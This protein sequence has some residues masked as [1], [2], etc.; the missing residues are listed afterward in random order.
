[1]GSSCVSRRPCGVGN[2]GGGAA[3]NLYRVRRGTG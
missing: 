2:G 1:M 3:R